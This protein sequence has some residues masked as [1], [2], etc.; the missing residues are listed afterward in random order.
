MGLNAVVY[1]S[2]QKL[3]P[4]RTTDAK[5]MRVDESTGEV[6]FEDGGAPVLRREDVVA[7]QKRLGNISLIASLRAEVQL[8]LASNYTSSLLSNVLRDGTHSGDVIGRGHLDLLNEELSLLEG[9]EKPLSRELSQFIS[10]MRELIVAAQQ[11]SNPIV[12]V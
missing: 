11:N 12:F 8:R 2:I 10:D 3:R 5:A 6:F 1:K 9:K 7:A 4:L